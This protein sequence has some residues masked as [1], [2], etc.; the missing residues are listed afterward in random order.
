MGQ[1]QK[2]IR[3]KEE[4]DQTE[5]A[6]GH[7]RRTREEQSWPTQTTHQ[8]NIW[9][10]RNNR[11]NTN[12]NS[13]TTETTHSIQITTAG[14]QKQY[15][16][17]T[18]GQ[19]KQHIQYKLQHLGKQKQHIQ[20]KLQHLGK[21]KQHIQYKLQQLDNRSNTSIEQPGNR[22]NTFNRTA[23]QQKQHIQ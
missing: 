12:Y 13:W 7:G 16:N 21:Q 4:K 11:L 20:Y 3:Q 15:I 8:Y 22:N 14:Q 10:N 18:A 17:R 19:Q 1:N 23:G 9:G 6:T 2:R 5:R